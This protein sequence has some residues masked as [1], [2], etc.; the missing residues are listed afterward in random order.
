MSETPHHETDPTT[1]PVAATPSS[2]PTYASA[3]SYAGQPAYVEPEKRR[4]KP[5]RLYQVAAW[6]GIAAGSVFIVAVIFFTG[7]ALGAH[8]GGGHHGGGHHG[9]EMGMRHHDGPQMRPNFIF[10]GGPGGPGGFGQ[11]GP[12]QGG[13]GGQP[14]QGGQGGQQGQPGQP[15]QSGQPGQFQPPAPRP[16]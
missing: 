14:G 10:P 1:S 15:G 5:H 3:P 2:E 8:S 16:S 6:V 11:F 13:Q 4:R 12:G 7:F 9:Q